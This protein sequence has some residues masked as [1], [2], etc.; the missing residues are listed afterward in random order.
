MDE[1]KELFAD[2]LLYVDERR[3]RTVKMYLR[4]LDYAERFLNKPAIAMGSHDLLLFKRMFL[5]GELSI[6]R[7][8]VK[9]IM[10]AVRAFKR[11]GKLHGHCELDDVELVRVPK[12]EKG[13]ANPLLPEEVQVL[14]DACERPNDFRLIYYGLYLGTRIGESARISGPMWRP[15]GFIR[16]PGEKKTADFKREIPIHPELE[17]VKWE[18][19]ASPPTYDSTLQRRK[20]RLEERTGVR[21]VTHQLRDTFSTYLYDEGVSDRIVKYWLGHAQDVTGLYVDLSRRR[22]KEGI[23]KLPYRASVA[24]LSLEDTLKREEEARREQITKRDEFVE[25]R[26]AARHLA[27]DDPTDALVRRPH[28][29]GRVLARRTLAAP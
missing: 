13:L 28:E 6:G 19:L 17:R 15:D 5:T 23:V 25:H 8:S 4:R 14:L 7:E 1:L 10:V 3:P 27:V 2:D 18:I 22:Q 24:Q 16:F 21:F 20:R 26:Q 9:G 12:T 11:W 29:V